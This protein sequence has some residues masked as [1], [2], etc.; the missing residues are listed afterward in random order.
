MQI[1]QI[2]QQEQIYIQKSTPNITQSSKNYCNTVSHKG[3]LGHER[4]FKNGVKHFLRHETALFRDIQTKNFVK[5]YILNN[6]SNKPQ[7]KMLVGACSTGEEVFTYSMLL[8][9][10]KSKLS[11]L[12]FD[13]SEKTIKQAKT[14]RVVMQELKSTPKNLINLY[15]THFNDSFLCF[16]T[17]N[18]LTQEQLEL[19]KLFDIFFEIQTKKYKNKEPIAYR[20]QRWFMAKF[21]NLALPKYDSKIVKFKKEKFTNYNFKVGDILN[22]T[23]ITKGEKVDVIT[24]TNAMYHLTT[25]DVAKGLLRFPKENTEDIV[26]DIAKNVKEN[27]N[28][29]G[30]FVL[31]ENEVEQMM[32]STSV[33]KVFKELGFEPLNKTEEHPENVWK[34]I[35]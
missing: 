26:R 29:N 9:S 35:K 14:G 20:V 27:L 25:D 10:L 3:H 7:I 4:I 6:F 23:E 5:N 16:K 15:P 34:L 19:K 17:K 8:D 21:L 2:K 12:G 24:F 33:P 32:D 18:L 22:L 11:I 30:I 1:L 28:P 13:L 31:G